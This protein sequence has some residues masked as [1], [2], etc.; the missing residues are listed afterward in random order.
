MCFELATEIKLHARKR[1]RMTTSVALLALKT[2]T[3]TTE[4]LRH[5]ML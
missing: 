3:E 4:V 1:Q 5:T 2:T